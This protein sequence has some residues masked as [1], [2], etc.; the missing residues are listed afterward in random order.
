V[1]WQVVST[2]D[3]HLTA[4]AFSFGV[5][6][7][8]GAG[9][10]APPHATSPSPSVLSIVGRSSLYMGIFTAIGTAF[11]GLWT[12]GAVLRGRRWLSI[13][14]GVLIT[15]GTVCMVVAE[16]STVGV[17]IGDLLR[18]AAGK[19]YV[20]LIAAAA[21]ALVCGVIAGVTRSWPPLALLGAAGIAT[22]LVRAL[23][24]HAAAASPAWP[25]E[26][27][28][29]VHIT[30]ASIWVGGF[31]PVLLLLWAWR[32]ARTA[33]D[34]SSSTPPVDEVARF[35]RAAGWAVLVLVV[36]G[37]FRE[38][39]EAGGPRKVLD[40]LFDSSYGTALLI[41]M[42]IVVGLIGLGW[43]NRR[44][45]I[46]RLRSGDGMLTR[47]MSIEVVLAVAVLVTTATLTGLNPE[48]T[49]PAQAAAPAR[50]SASGSDFATT[51]RVEMT[52]TPGTPGRNE[53]RVE[54][55]DFDSGDPLPATAVTLRFEPVGRPNVQQSHLDLTRAGD[56]AWTGSGTQL[57]L[58]G[59]W[60]VTA[61]V[62]T[63]ARAT[64]VPL[65]LVTRAPGGQ[66][67]SVASQAGLPD[68]TTITLASGSQI[69]AYADPGTQGANEVH[70]TAFDASGQEL[71]L[72]D[73][74]VVATPKDGDPG[75]LDAMRLS[76]GHFSAAADLTAGEW[77]F[78]IVTTSKD[79]QV[80][81][82]WFNQRV[83][84]ASP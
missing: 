19:D 59:V 75:A 44:R 43:L 20:W 11:A 32:S 31:V 62:E 79:G 7:A 55:N 58:A 64:E 38:L 37:V 45:S 81:Q 82:V 53:F 12:I 70:V 73:M 56:G 40:L 71:P 65:A 50:I 54:V 61:L 22:A 3:G 68:I 51:M 8:P 28:Q 15:L 66:Q 34:R 69:Q 1:S 26:L 48:P 49:T 72:Q 76:A 33:T 4:N 74:L 46:P 21:V 77:R 24:G 23:G 14:S 29:T 13:A 84:Q 30:A 47:V 5:G 9:S 67:M 60:N 57:S 16:R 41:K 80:L 52:T 18:S 35:S 2:A 25:Q 78:D 27:L 63:G 36:T 6:V 17:A 39:N 42:A 83:G 10:T